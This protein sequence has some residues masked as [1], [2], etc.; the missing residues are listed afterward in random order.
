MGG[1]GSR[2]VQFDNRESCASAQGF[3]VA[4]ANIKAPYI[5]TR[6]LV[7]DF[8]ERRAQWF[9]IEVRAVLKDAALAVIACFYQPYFFGWCGNALSS[10]P[11][12]LQINVLKEA[13]PVILRDQLCDRACSVAHHKWESLSRNAEDFAFRG[14]GKAIIENPRFVRTRH[15]G[16]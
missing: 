6:N 8:I 3:V 7:A 1:F 2:T 13:R 9:R 14:T 11:K 15:V 5:E 16:L 12:T 10:G 4:I